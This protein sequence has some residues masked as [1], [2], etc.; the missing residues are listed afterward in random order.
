MQ[1][2]AAKLVTVHQPQLSM[3]RE[4]PVAVDLA[5]LRE[6]CMPGRFMGLMVKSIV[7]LRWCTYSPV[8][9]PVVAGRSQLAVEHDGVLT[10]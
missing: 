7:D 3:R 5:L 8:M 10:S 2:S 9:V 1:L 4:I 6:G